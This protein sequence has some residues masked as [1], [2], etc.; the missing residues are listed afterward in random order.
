MEHQDKAQ[1][2]QALLGKPQH[3]TEGR[4]L[5]VC[6]SWGTGQMVAGDTCLEECW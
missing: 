2:S 5:V 1:A 4:V 3:L 6:S